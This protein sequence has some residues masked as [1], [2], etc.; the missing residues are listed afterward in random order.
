MENNWYAREGNPHLSGSVW[1]EEEQSYNFALFSREATGVVLVI[2][3]DSDFARPIFEFKFD[4]LANK[5]NGVWHCR[6]PKNSIYT[7]KYYAYRVEGSWKPEDGQR[8]DSN[9]ILL[10]PFARAV[11]FPP[12]F[13]RI[14]ASFSG[15]N[16]G[17]APLGSLPE[18]EPAFDWENDKHIRHT[19]EAIIYELHVKAFTFRSNSGL[20]EFQRGTFE[21]ISEKIPYLKELGITIV[22]LLPVFQS[23]P[24]DPE[25]YWG[26]MPLS[27]FSPQFAYAGLHSGGTVKNEFRKM[28]K[29]LHEAGIEVI[30]DVVYN[31]TV[32]ADESGPTYSYRGIDNSTY[33]L[34]TEDMK[35]YRNDS[36]TGNTMRCAH[37]YVR[38]LI[39]ESMRYWVK[40]M[41]IDGFRF[42][43]ASIFARN[44]DGSLNLDDPP[45]I[46][47]IT[48]DP[49]FA[50]LRLIAE[51]WDQSSFL[52][53]KKFPG[54]NWFQWN[55]RYRD[56]VRA[57]VK[58][59]P[60]SIPSLMARLYGSCDL[61]P[62][63]L[64]DA[65]RPYQS[66]NFV[67]CHDGFCLYDL[68]AYNDKHNELNGKDNK[69]GLAYN[70]SW[71]CGHEGDMN[72]SEEVT[73]LR[74]RQVRNFCV[75]LFLSNGT[76]MFYAGDEFL[77]TQQGNNN[78]YNQDNEVTWLNWDL[79][80]KNKDI[81][82]FFKSMISFRKAHPSICRSQYWRED[83]T[84]Y[85]AYEK[86]PDISFNSHCLAFC[87]HGLSQN[88]AD[89]YVMINAYWENIPFTIHE[90]RP[91]EWIRVCDTHFPYADDT[92]NPEKY[93]VID[94][95]VYNVNA[96]SI[97]VLLKK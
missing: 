10:D 4:P 60:G 65:Y 46:S 49:D 53:G 83:I 71:N 76:P 47:E 32:E 58:S 9:K 67:T 54:S 50:N 62:D 2:Y 59:D 94:A 23:D 18:K 14:A 48:S 79:L 1:V 74:K 86:I 57:F 85:G 34:L 84:W 20:T 37:P 33:Y 8:F 41:H 91:E 39:V 6:I 42:D 13:S 17:K 82:D 88:D 11:F 45:I 64:N 63:T 44:Y 89:I 97:V 87:L 12:E 40:E 25:T 90:G 52:L 81:Y 16:A 75:I 56:D 93:H 5:S 15:S 66:I 70:L 69:D 92:I 27:F 30:L 96:R 77:N 72:V 31:H 73:A 55:A 3:D 22:E 19:N 51:V 7:G 35:H 36:G 28:I 24:Q 61:F 80:Q 29:Q 21:G 78:P 95:S 43:L 26:Y 68:V 38:R